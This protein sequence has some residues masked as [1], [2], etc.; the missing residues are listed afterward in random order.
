MSDPDFIVPPPGLVPDAPEADRG[1]GPEGTVRAERALPG[2][3][4]PPGIRPPSALPIAPSGVAPSGA[5]PS[6]AAPSVAGRSAAVPAAPAEPSAPHAPTGSWRLRSADG[7]AFQVIDRVVAGRDPSPPAWLHG[8]VLMAIPDHTR[9]MS[10]THALLES[11]GGRLLVTDLDSTNG[12]RVW[13][14]GEEPVDLEPGVPAEAPL[15]AVILLGDVAFLVER[16]PA[17]SV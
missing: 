7:I 9:S 13:P 15:D 11:S 12:V 6:G 17:Q 14:D 16:A 8:A 10:K 5:A 4:P 1:D 3:R 2:F